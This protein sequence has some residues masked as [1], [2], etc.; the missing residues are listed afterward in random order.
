MCGGGGFPLRRTVEM[1]RAGRKVDG[2]RAGEE[3]ARSESVGVGEE[4]G[5]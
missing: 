5:G 3:R 2:G 1:R 4:V